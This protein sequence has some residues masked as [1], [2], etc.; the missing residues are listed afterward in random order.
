MDGRLRVL[1]GHLRAVRWHWIAAVAGTW[2]LVAVVAS[3]LFFLS[4]ERTIDVA[5]HEA[6]LRPT[7]T[8][9][10]VVRTG[11]VLP[12]LRDST[13]S[14][15]GVEIVLGKTDAASLDELSKRYAAIAANPDAQIE[16]V[17]DAI[18]GMAVESGLRG[19]AT[20]V[21][22]LLVWKAIGRDRRRVLAAKVRT[23]AGLAAALAVWLVAA[24]IVAPWRYVERD[25]PREQWESLAAFVGPDVD[26][27]SEAKGV[28]VRIDA[29]TKESRRLVES[30]VS[31]Y[32][33]GNDFYQEAADSAADLSLR[34][35]SVGET[36]V[37]L[38][39]DRHD[40][41][42]M[43]PVAR[44]VADRGGATAVFDAGDDT[45]TGEPWEAF[46]LD[47]LA[48]EYDDLPRWAVAG[49]H[50]HGTFVR[51][52]LEDRGWTYFDG[53]PRP[54]PG[55]SRVLGVD[56]PRS[57]GLGNWRD[58]T[59]LTFDEVEHRLA[60]AACD[61]AENGDRVGTVLVHDANLGDEALARGCV[62][63]VVGGHTHVQDG[64]TRVR[65]E[66]GEVG[67]T[68][69]TGT[70]GGAAYAIA[71][72]KLRRPAGLSLITYRNGRPVGIQGIT[73]QTTGR[74]DVSPWAPLTYP[75]GPSE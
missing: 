37:L 26:L 61:A 2:L 8:G 29:T 44:A 46:S 33:A 38:V 23:P 66:N 41:I 3:V 72:G 14:L 49:N 35:P 39:S 50:D 32:Q 58:E 28:E 9:Q 24:A 19:A 67:Y 60:D 34:Q 52:H 63:L 6:T 17:Q 30:A 62:D 65:G 55:G 20:G 27:P 48:S 10:A 16:N 4:S 31:G 40:N 59:G 21:V 25:A 57:S 74:W 53:E 51:E 15:V 73:L 5:S 36:V 13:G 54:G 42:G 7:L 18:V 47:S 12:D 71:I 43:D 68:Y 69:T 75:P 22:P 11:P 64:P 1:R 70:A 56:D 45:S